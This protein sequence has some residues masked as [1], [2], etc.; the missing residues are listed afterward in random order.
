VLLK[1]VLLQQV[2][3]QQVLLLLLTAELEEQKEDSTT[4]VDLKHLQAYAQQQA[5]QL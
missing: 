4:R 2:L 1:Q 3:L 5:A